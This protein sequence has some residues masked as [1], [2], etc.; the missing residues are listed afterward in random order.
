[1]LCRAEQAQ[2]ERSAFSNRRVESSVSLRPQ[3]TLGRR[4][5]GQPAAS[6]ALCIVC[7]VCRLQAMH[8]VCA[9]VCVASARC[10]GK[11]PCCLDLLRPSTHQQ[12][13]AWR[14]SLHRD[15][16]HAAHSTT[17]SVLAQ[18]QPCCWAGK[19][20]ARAGA[21]ACANTV[22][23]GLVA[24]VQASSDRLKALIWGQNTHTHCTTAFLCGDVCTY[25][26]AV[27]RNRSHD[28]K[29]QTKGDERQ[30]CSRRM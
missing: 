12:P 4:Q 29:H 5:S 15:S 16:I 27:V 3:A 26:F 9:A 1:V 6:A 30:S 20:C 14:A 7:L 23:W 22:L 10:W 25:P 18:Q 8:W 28:N 13:P 21:P 2:R 19:C 11:L 17:S 24:V